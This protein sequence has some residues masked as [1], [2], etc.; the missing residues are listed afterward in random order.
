MVREAHGLRHLQ[1][2]EAGHDGLRV[3]F[4]QIQQSGLQA[5]QQLGDGVDLAAQPQAH[6]GCD[7]V[8][9]G[10]PGVQALARVAH[11]LG[12]ACLDI[13]VHVFQRQLPFKLSAADFMANL[14]QAAL[15]VGQIL[16]ADD[17]LRRQHARVRQA[18]VD[19]GL[20][21]PLVKVD[22]GGVALHQLA[23]GFRE[24]RRPGLGLFI[25]LVCHRAILR[26]C[27]CRAASRLSPYCAGPPQSR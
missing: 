20:P 6:V 3:L 5:V 16:G 18:A 21:Q 24:Q 12:E 15:D 8:V 4:G 14:R 26:R 11:Q 1:V 19:I 27:P 9:A 13:E 25:E 17:A 7:L 2:G 10:A 22:A 23:D